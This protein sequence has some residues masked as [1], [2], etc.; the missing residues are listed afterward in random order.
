VTTPFQLRY[1][2]NWSALTR[3]G[4]ITIGAPVLSVSLKARL[5]S[6]TTFVRVKA[7]GLGETAGG[8][9]QFASAL[10]LD[11]PIVEAAGAE[12]PGNDRILVGLRDRVQVPQ[13]PVEGISWLGNYGWIDRLMHWAIESP[14][15]LGPKNFI[16]CNLRLTERRRQDGF[17][18]K[19]LERVCH[20]AR[21]S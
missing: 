7:F 12:Q 13:Q 6:A 19:H 5:I 11:P 10:Q 14:D 18:G 3:A 16:F 1:F 4:L 20:A 2:P 17:V 15:N 21:I 9:F 8:L